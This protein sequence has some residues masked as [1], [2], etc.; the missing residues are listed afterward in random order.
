MLECQHLNRR[1]I[2]THYRGPR[3]KILG[4]LDSRGH[5]SVRLLLGTAEK[6]YL[7]EWGCL[8]ISTRE[9]G[10]ECA[11]LVPERTGRSFSSRTQLLCQI[12][13]AQIFV[14]WKLST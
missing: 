7:L 1:K 13:S 11:V 2:T 5:L 10:K 4:F 3:S 9:A 8:V 14:A 12:Y 6:L